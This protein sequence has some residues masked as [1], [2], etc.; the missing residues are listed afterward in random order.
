MKRIVS[1]FTIILLISLPVCVFASSNDGADAHSQS[2]SAGS[3][4][5]VVDESE[6]FDETVDQS[7]EEENQETPDESA[8]E[9]LAEDAEEATDSMFSTMS[10]NWIYIAAGLGI[11]VLIIVI[12]VAIKSSKG[13]HKNQIGSKSYK[14]KH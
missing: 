10:N 11:V 5:L 14:P 1:I 8:G 12:V 2:M 7:V 3:E 6:S 9:E 13:K 4:E